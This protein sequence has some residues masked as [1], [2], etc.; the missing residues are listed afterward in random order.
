MNY[1]DLARID[2][3]LTELLTMRLSDSTNTY[4]WVTANYH[5]LSEANIAVNEALSGDVEI[6]ATV[7]C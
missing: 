2:A 7:D 5:R 4:V 3:L 1:K 6:A